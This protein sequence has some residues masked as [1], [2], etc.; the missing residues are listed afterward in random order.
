MITLE[1]KVNNCV[2]VFIRFLLHVNK[3][4]LFTNTVSCLSSSFQIIKWDYSENFFLHLNFMPSLQHTFSNRFNQLSEAL[5]VF[6][7]LFFCTEILNGG[8]YVGQNKF[9]CFA[10]TIHWQDIVRNPWASNFTLVPTNGSSGCKYCFYSQPC[11]PLS[12]KQDKY[13]HKFSL[14]L[15]Y[16]ELY[17]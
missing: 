4:F 7:L 2:S 6:I 10:D 1:Q 11:H 14:I 8:V 13:G 15:S 17:W 16:G 5:Q 12:M 9:L 3:G